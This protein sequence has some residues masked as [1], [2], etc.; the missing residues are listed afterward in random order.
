MTNK[1]KAYMD[2]KEDLESKAKL[3]NV[4]SHSI[5]V[6]CDRCLNNIEH[7]FLYKV[8]VPS[9][10]DLLEGL[11]L[12]NDI[13][14]MQ[15]SKLLPFV[16]SENKDSKAEIESIKLLV[17]MNA[18]DISGTRKKGAYIIQAGEAILQVNTRSFGSFILRTP[19]GGQLLE[20]NDKIIG[21]HELLCKRDYELGFI[22][23]VQPNTPIP[24][25]EGH[26]CT[27]YDAL[28]E[29]LVKKQSDL[30]CR[31]FQEGRCSRGDLCR[32]KHVISSDSHQLTIKKPKTTE[33]V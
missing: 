19:I 24:S 20:F 16:Y 15:L 3:P 27:S 25:I 18:H 10:L 12:P 30:V 4:T 6:A 14:V 31:P 23:I 32:F 21:D 28:V 13:C 33:N 8:Y 29:Y 9:A 7:K 2:R 11:V 26:K 1:R 17:D 5:A 22:C